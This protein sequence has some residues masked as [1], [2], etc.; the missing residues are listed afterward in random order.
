MTA[1]VSS[2][3]R[4]IGFP[5]RS[6]VMV[7]RLRPAPSRRSM[8]DPSLAVAPTATVSLLAPFVMDKRA[9]P[10]CVTSSNARICPPL[11]TA[12]GFA[13]EDRPLRLQRT[14]RR[15]ATL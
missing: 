2:A 13:G 9:S 11:T 6:S 14:E 5:V 12:S 1:P 3:I 8:N 15:K 7:N 10:S 4:I